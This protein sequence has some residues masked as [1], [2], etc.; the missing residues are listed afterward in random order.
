MQVIVLMFLLLAFSFGS[1]CMPCDTQCGNWSCITNCSLGVSNPQFDT[2][3]CAVD[4]NGNGQ[5]DDCNEL[6]TCFWSGSKYVC[7]ADR[8]DP[9]CTSQ[10]WQ[11]P[12]PYDSNPYD[13][14]API[15]AFY[16]TTNSVYYPQYEQLLQ[17]VSLPCADRN[18][19]DAIRS[20][21]GLPVWVCG[22]ILYSDAWLSYSTCDY[23]SFDGA[24]WKVKN[25]DCYNQTKIWQKLGPA[26][27]WTSW[28]HYLYLWYNNQYQYFTLYWY[29]WPPQGNFDSSQTI[30][31][32]DA[33]GYYQPHTVRLR[34]VSSTNVI[35]EATGQTINLC[36]RFEQRVSGSLVNY[37]VYWNMDTS[38]SCSW[39]SNYVSSSFSWEYWYVSYQGQFSRVIEERP[40]YRTA[41]GVGIDT[42]EQRCRICATN[43][44][45]LSGGVV[46]SVP[47]PDQNFGPDFDKLAQCANPRFFSGEAR[48]CR[49]GGI[50]VLGASCCG[51]SGWMKGMCSRGEKELKKKREANICT[52]VGTYCSKKVLGFCLERKR[53]YCCFNSW[54]A[55][56]FNECGRPQIGKGWGSAKRPN[57]SGFTIDEFARIDFAD[58]RCARAIE[59]WAMQ[60]A[61][62]VGDHVGSDI[63]N[64][65]TTQIQDWLQNVQN[66]KGYGGDK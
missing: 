46:K 44:M 24:M 29:A 18:L 51:I 33:R 52:Y 34:C 48:T 55:R 23:Y 66:K 56:I 37:V 2:Y 12:Y 30:Y 45:G 5:I 47:D 39:T 53:S 58:E 61:Q 20:K 22:G 38:W 3:R 50:T 36:T 57:C 62:R 60:M 17:R 6:E 54:L 10:D 4:K 8:N 26:C 31:V 11:G 7:N 1:E 27:Y 35:D 63:A 15:W 41:K 40:N 16:I 9:L 21:F 64:R 14:D 43:Y 65:A 59:E 49:P 32:M 28:T 42:T 19:A 25:N 13:P